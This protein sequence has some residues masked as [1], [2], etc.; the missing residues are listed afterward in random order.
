MPQTP[1]ENVVAHWHKLIGDFQTSP[2][3]F[4]TAVELALEQRNILGLKTSRVKWSEGGILSP[5][6]EYLRVTGDRH[7]F[8]MCAAPF[9]TG[10]FFSSWLTARKARFVFLVFVLLVLATAILNWLFRTVFTHIWRLD[11]S[12]LWFIFRNPWVMMLVV[13]LLLFVVVLWLVALTA[14][15]GKAD[16]ELAVL[17]MPLIGAFYKAVFAPDTYYRI[18]TMLMFQSM[19]HSA[20]L[21]VIDGLT[22]QKGVRGLSDDDRKPVFYKLM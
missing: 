10:F 13:P 8:D 2:K 22:T 6:R 9:G 3:D 1:L 15:M 7:S 11:V 18:D 14:R 17:A 20:M 5:D 16:P 4:Y 21:D 12:P 19:V